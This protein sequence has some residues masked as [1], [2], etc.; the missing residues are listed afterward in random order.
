MLVLFGLAWWNTVGAEPSELYQRLGLEKAATSAEI[1]RAY[2]A[3]ARH[4][5][6]DKVEGDKAVA[7]EKFKRL[8]EA[9]E[10]LTDKKLRVEYDRTGQIPDDRAKS[11]A[12]Q[13]STGEEEEFGYGG[14]R[15]APS[16][17]QQWGRR[18]E[19]YDAFEVRL[20]QGRARRARSL[21]QLRKH[22]HAP[23][24]TALRYGL[25]GFYRAGDEAALKE[26]LKFPY[27]FAGWSLGREGSGFWCELQIAIATLTLAP[28]PGPGPGPDRAAHP[29]C[30]VGGRDSDLP[31]A[32]RRQLQR[33]VR[34]A[35]PLRPLG[36]PPLT[37][38]P[39]L[40]VTPSLTLSPSPSLT[41][42]PSP[43][44]TLSPSS[45]LTLS[46][47]SSLT[48]SPSSSLTLIL[49]LT[50]ALTLT[51]TLTRPPR[52]CPPSRGCARTRRCPSS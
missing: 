34:P 32:H 21:A 3:Q 20:A 2:H 9:Y 47:S 5:H 52:R 44:L 23:N 46:P 1:R 35:A 7:A 33:A 4:T 29:P 38:D 6:P 11:A 40:P 13:Q 10:V 25:V 15:P 37:C 18:Y 8:A 43:S 14:A 51:L 12:N 28:D 27:P 19:S 31:R 26:R 24:G 42:S 45:S 16:A 30:Q 50:L 41:L 48:L 22:L 39:P 17:P 36:D 49:S